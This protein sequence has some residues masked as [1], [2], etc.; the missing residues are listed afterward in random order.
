MDESSASRLAGQEE[1]QSSDAV[2]AEEGARG[3]AE[4]LHRPVPFLSLPDDL[5]YLVYSRFFDDAYPD[6]REVGETSPNAYAVL[7]NKRIFKLCSPL[8]HQNL[9]IS[10]EDVYPD[11]A[12]GHLMA[13]PHIL[14]LVRRLDTAVPASYPKLFAAFLRLLPNLISLALN[15]DSDD[16]FCDTLPSNLTDCFRDLKHL[17]HLRIQG[18]PDLDDNKFNLKRDM[19]SLERLDTGCIGALD[20]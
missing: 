12:F 11:D 16:G 10:A 19:P 1:S 9:L 14:P 8:L 18:N 17:R 3:T 6:G 13:R 4:D 5:I 7:V 2:K 15:F 20:T